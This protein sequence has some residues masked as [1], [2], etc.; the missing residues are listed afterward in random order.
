MIVN[1]NTNLKNILH[2]SPWLKKV[3][4]IHNFTDLDYFKPDYNLP[5]N[6]KNKIYFIGVGKYSSQKNI[7]NLVEIS[8]SL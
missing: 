3:S 8:F 7:V 6:N 4:L 1:S 2:Y 5:G